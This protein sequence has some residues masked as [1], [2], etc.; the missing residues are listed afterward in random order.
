LARV[1]PRQLHPAA[2][3]SPPRSE[4]TGVSDAPGIPREEIAVEGE[5]HS[6]AIEAITAGGV[7]AECGTGP[8]SGGIGGNG[9][10]SVPARGRKLPQKPLDLSAEG[11]RGDRS[12]Q[13]AQAR[14]AGG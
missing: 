14:A 11:R 2:A 4:I 3:D 8:R 9:V 7:A 12:R 1:E 10:P 5:D 6:R 13:E